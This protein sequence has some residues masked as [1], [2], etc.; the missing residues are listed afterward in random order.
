MKTALSLLVLLFSCP[1][2][3]PAI[4]QEPSAYR[5]TLDY[6]HKNGR[7]WGVKEL[8][9]GTNGTVT[10]V[11]AKDSGYGHGLTMY[12]AKGRAVDQIALSPSQFCSLS[13]GR[14]VSTKY[15]LQAVE[16]GVIAMLVTDRINAQSFGKGVTERTEV[17][18]LK[19]YKDEPERR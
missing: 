6:I 14:H 5:D 1:A 12:D 16:D 18:R 17:A 11:D 7:L 2:L 13:D 9:L 10:L 19:P 15:G 3:S 8:L 4:A